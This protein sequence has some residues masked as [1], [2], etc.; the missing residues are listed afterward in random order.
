MRFTRV[1]VASA[2]LTG[3]SCQVCILALGMMST[4]VGGGLLSTSSSMVCLSSAASSATIVSNRSPLLM[5][6]RHLDRGITNDFYNDILSDEQNS[7]VSLAISFLRVAKYMP[8][9]MRCSCRE[10]IERILNFIDTQV[11]MLEAPIRKLA[12]SFQTNS[13][14]G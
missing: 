11:V 4:A 7:H 1:L 10:Q 12:H 13:C 5:S 2:V 3:C 14:R 6:S 9:S 8:G